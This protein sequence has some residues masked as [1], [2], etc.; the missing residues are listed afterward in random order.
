MSDYQSSSHTVWECKYHI[1][2]IPKYRR[3]TLY[4]QIRKEL[5]EAFHR[6]AHQKEC[7]IE[8]GFLM[9][10]HVHMLVSIPPK[11]SV[12]QIIGFLKGKTAI[13]VAHRYGN[14]RK[15]FIGQH[16]WARGYHVST[17]GHDEAT[18]R[19]YIENQEA[20]DKRNDQQQNLFK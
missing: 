9:P 13:Y 2:F 16:F 12:A 1:V 8:S 18:V 11:H 19:R 3:K 20:E 10:D 7:R 14:V 4:G 17:V 15:N 6:L 5:Q